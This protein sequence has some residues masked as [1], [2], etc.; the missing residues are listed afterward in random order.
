MAHPGGRPPKFETPEDLEA[1]VEEYKAAFKPGGM[2]EGDIPD[3][4]HFCEFVDSYRDLLSAYESKKEYS[5]TIKRLKNFMY[6]RKKQLA[7]TNK[8]NATVYI[9]DAKNNHGYKDQSEIKSDET[10][11]HTYEELDDEQLEAALKARENR[12]T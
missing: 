5:D 10:V 1:R 2:F 8:L 6:N 7:M 4:E 3:V 11:H 9:F 12:T